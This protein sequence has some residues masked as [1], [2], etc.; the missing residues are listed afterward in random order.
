MNPFT[1]ML[2][3][4]YTLHYIALYAT[5]SLAAADV[6][7]NS[8]VLITMMYSQ[9]RFTNE[10]IGVEKGIWGRVRSPGLGICSLGLMDLFLGCAV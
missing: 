1:I 4:L 6:H 7:D 5:D 9:F 10:S 2:E 3:H 8:Q